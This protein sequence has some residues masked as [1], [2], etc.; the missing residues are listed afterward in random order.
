MS[1]CRA[2]VLGAERHFFGQPEPF[3]YSPILPLFA[4]LCGIVSSM[5][6]LHLYV[7]LPFGGQSQTATGVLGAAEAGQYFWASGQSSSQPVTLSWLV[8]AVTSSGHFSSSL[9]LGPGLGLCLAAWALCDQLQLPVP[10]MR[11]ACPQ[12]RLC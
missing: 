8:L 7:T 4:I 1:G 2:Q 6:G 10:E 5:V 12:P 3:S 11:K 9:A